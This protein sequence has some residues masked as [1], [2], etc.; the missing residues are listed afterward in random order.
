MSKNNSD[1]FIDW[2]DT[3]YYHILYKKRDELEAQ[4]FISNL[5]KSLAIQ[6]EAKLLDLACGKGRHSI[7]LNSLGYDVVG[8]DLSKNSIELAKKHENESLH[9]EVQD[10][11]IPLQ[12]KKFNYIFN[13]FT[14][15][16]YFEVFEDNFKTLTSIDY[17]LEK[18]GVFI[19]DFFNTQKVVA[20]LKPFESKI[21]DRIEFK[22]SKRIENNFIIKDIAF[23]AD[24]K[25]FQFQE[26]VAALTLSYF[27]NNFH[28]IGLKIEAIYGD[29][30]LEPYNISQ[31]N[32]M[33]LVAKKL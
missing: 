29:Y 22:I 9:F 14:S 7:Y 12:G 18:N 24:N 2:F 31:S 21:V 6:K 20:E 25:S 15:F 4:H 10:M 3:K 26:R 19:I 17:M 1:W 16:G 32:R 11:R 33:I 13:L 30:N 8:V 5:V 27:E 23:N 28:K